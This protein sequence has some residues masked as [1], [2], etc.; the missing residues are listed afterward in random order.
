MIDNYD[1]FT[2]NLVQLFY[3]F[4]IQ[5][6]V[7]RHD[8]IDIPEIRSMAHDWICISPGPKDP[9][10]AGVSMEVVRQFGDRVPIL[11]V[12][13]GMQVIN[14]A[15][16][17]KTRRAPVPVHG[18]RSRVFHHGEGLFAGLP[19]PFWVARYHSLCIAPGSVDIIPVARAEDGVIM[20][21]RHRAWPIHGVQFHPESFLTEHG[22]EVS[23]APAGI[24]WKRSAPLGPARPIP[25]VRRGE[26]SLQ[27]P[28]MD[29]SSPVSISSLLPQTKVSIASCRALG[30]PAS[31]ADF[32]ERARGIAR[33]S[34]S[35]IL[36]S[37]GLPTSDAERRHSV[38][39]WD[40]YLIFTA[41]GSFCSIRKGA[42]VTS[43]R[44]SPL[45]LLDA[46]TASVRPAEG[47]AVPPFS[48]GA[49]GYLAYDLKNVIERLPRTV[50]DDLLPDLWLIWPRQILVHDRQE[51]SLTHL[52]LDYGDGGPWQLS[53]IPFPRP[54]GEVRTPPP[55]VGPLSS[56]FTREAYMEA[57]SR[58]REYIRAGDVYQV[59][60]SQRYRLDFTGD[61]FRLWEALFARNPA[62]FYAYLNCGGHQV[63]ST[64]M[65]RFLLR[66]GELMETRPIKGTRKRGATREEDE[67]LRRDLLSSPKDDAELSMIVDLLRNDMGRACLPRTI[68]VLE[69]KRLESYQNVHHLVSI[70][71]GRLRPGV[72][73]GDILRATFPGGS[74]TGCPKIRAMEI[75][76][77]LETVA[78]HVYT[79]SVGYLGWH[80]NMDLNI[81]IRTAVIHRG[82]CSFSVGGG[83]V[84]DSDEAEEYEETLHK[85]R[86]LFEIIKETAR[87]AA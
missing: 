25:P 73:Y 20:G 4:D 76:D 11:G 35:A 58:I 8:A 86:T 24:P 43:F 83:V 9:A 72:T 23:Q 40:P 22:L 57:V 71:T 69:H 6:D 15:F 65:E 82:S 63:L 36:L 64:S 28:Q 17:G 84:Y 67:A 27:R 78:R 49:L 29:G 30:R 5:V 19:S 18:K 1:S 48:G 87:S 80:D 75:I 39:A 46:L 74:I 77:E 41:K 52:V 37:G 79:G 51:G 85:G 33:Q 53:D 10:H 16:G 54:E 32:M 2:Y 70:V 62:A 66:R 34:G 47:L 38:A 45:A 42:T 7:F 12:C 44:E 56:N 14:E 68:R 60:L 21:I 26:S 13:L 31:D 81:A 3:E 61:P 59:N 55:R 50:P